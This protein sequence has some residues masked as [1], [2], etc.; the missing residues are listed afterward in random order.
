MGG[1]GVGVVGGAGVKVGLGPAPIVVGVGGLGARGSRVGVIAAGAR[2]GVGL[3]ATTAVPDSASPPR[4]KA[5]AI[6]TTPAPANSARVETA[7]TR[8]RGVTGH[9]L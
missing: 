4:M 3:A 8:L 7:T 6:M 2:V 1:R 5:T 9:P